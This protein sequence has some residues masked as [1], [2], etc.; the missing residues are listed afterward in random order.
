LLV[1]SY[2]DFNETLFRQEGFSTFV[3]KPFEAGD[4]VRVVSSFLKK[5]VERAEGAEVP[6]SRVVPPL[7]LSSQAAAGAEVRAAVP[8]PPP[9]PSL[10]ANPARE[11]EEQKRAEPERDSAEPLTRTGS[12]KALIWEQDTAP[13]LHSSSEVFATAALDGED[14]ESLA[15]SEPVQP[16]GVQ[17]PPR[18]Q[19]AVEADNG[20]KEP[21]SAAAPSLDID[22]A[23]LLKEHLASI[24][25]ERIEPLIA[26]EVEVAVR[27]YLEAY[28][29]KNFK[30][31]AREILT[32]EIRRLTDEKARQMLDDD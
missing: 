1:G 4:I 32:S 25:E 11:G 5:P 27:R 3:R 8:P 18:S 9:V 30:P 15:A 7:P 6:A 2:E 13:D 23:A 31:L 19:P 22:A 26:R 17:P 12:K 21:A 28:V 20:F 29:E 14:S 10:K 16:H 24:M